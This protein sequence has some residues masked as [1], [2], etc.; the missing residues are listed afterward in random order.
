MTIPDE[1]HFTIRMRSLP[2][3][4]ATASKN[5]DWLTQNEGFLPPAVPG[6][7]TLILESV[8]RQGAP[9]LFLLLDVSRD[10]CFDACAK[11][12]LRSAG[13]V[14]VVA[15]TNRSGPTLSDQLRAPT[16]RDCF[17]VHKLQVGSAETS[18]HEPAMRLLKAP[19]LCTATASRPKRSHGFAQ[20]TASK[21]EALLVCH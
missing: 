4:G 15:S 10:L 17:L 7:S 21:T 9:I 6:G 8:R 19:A 11:H 13:K 18:Q 20:D 3:S 1:L 14:L 5:I 12:L 16:S 2:P